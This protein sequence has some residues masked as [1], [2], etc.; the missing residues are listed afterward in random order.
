MYSC[1]GRR[2]FEHRLTPTPALAQEQARPRLFQLSRTS[3]VSP[4][5]PSHFVLSCI[6]IG[7]RNVL[8]SFAHSTTTP[9]GPI[10]PGLPVVYPPVPG[11]SIQLGI[12]LN[13]SHSVGCGG[14]LVLISLN[15]CHFH[16][17]GTCRELSH[18]SSPHPFSSHF[19]CGVFL[20][21]TLRFTPFSLVCPWTL[22]RSWEHLSSSFSFPLSLSRSLSLFFLIP[23]L[24]LL[25]VWVSL[26]AFVIAG[27]PSLLLV[28][29][30]TLVS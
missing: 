9:R 23:F 14:C 22:V 6:S 2:T 21:V 18:P 27:N 4:A 5:V 7:C 17:V 13:T 1:L 30:W 10:L 26:D 25:L 3:V 19:V 12:F 16:F 24:S 29:P 8:P 15:P 20:N 28:C 11:F